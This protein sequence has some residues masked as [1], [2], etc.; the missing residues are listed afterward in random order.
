MAPHKQMFPFT[1]EE[2][3]LPP[4]IPNHLLRNGK[5][6]KKNVRIRSL[7]DPQRQRRPSASTIHSNHNTN[8]DGNTSQVGTYRSY[9]HGPFDILHR[10]LWNYQNPEH[11]EY[12]PNSKRDPNYEKRARQK[13]TTQ[14]QFDHTDDSPKKTVYNRWN[15]DSELQHERK[16]RKITPRNRTRSTVLKQNTNRM[17]PMPRTKPSQDAFIITK[18]DEESSYNNISSLDKYEHFIPYL[19][20]DD[21]LDPS[22]AFSPIPP[23]RETSAHTQQITVRRL[24]LRLFI[25]SVF[26]HIDYNYK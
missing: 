13:H 15:S 5:Q 25:F 14:E 7:E 9:H 2:S 4:Q 24:D 21:V 10:P 17:E 18:T 3:D 11:R 1:R 12:V 8:D 20:T 23:S 16:E 6:N 19:R 26:Y 22:K